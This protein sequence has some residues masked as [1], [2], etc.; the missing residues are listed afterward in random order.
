MSV[1]LYLRKCPVAM[2]ELAVRKAYGDQPFYLE[3]C[4]LLRENLAL[5]FAGALLGFLF[6]CIFL[7]SGARYW[8]AWRWCL[9]NE[10]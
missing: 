3:W 2:A 4:Q 5:A 1:D 10:F 7:W 9:R 8:Y 6:S